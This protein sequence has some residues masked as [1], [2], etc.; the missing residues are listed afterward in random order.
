MQFLIDVS[1]T[2]RVCENRWLAYCSTSNQGFSVRVYLPLARMI[3]LLKGADTRDRLLPLLLSFD[4]S[5]ILPGLR[6]G[7]AT[8]ELVAEPI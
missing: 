8:A 1:V 2:N 6:R 3:P 7:R 4:I 5:Y